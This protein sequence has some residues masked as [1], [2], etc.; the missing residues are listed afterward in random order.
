VSV[1]EPF[2]VHGEVEQ[3]EPLKHALEEKGFLAVHIPAPNQIFEI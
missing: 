3:S 2:L 1:H